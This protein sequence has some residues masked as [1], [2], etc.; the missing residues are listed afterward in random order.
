MLYPPFSASRALA[1]RWANLS[2]RLRRWVYAANA[3]APA[4][5]GFVVVHQLVFVNLPLFRIVNGPGKVSFKAFGAV[6]R[7]EGGGAGKSRE[8]SLTRHGAASIL[9]ILRLRA[10]QS[11]EV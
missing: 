8:N 3:V 11:S 6:G 9:G 10:L 2:S 7:G 4:D 5:G 1:F